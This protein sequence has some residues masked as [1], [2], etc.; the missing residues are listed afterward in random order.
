[1]AKK[2]VW[3]SF[4]CVACGGPSGG[5][6]AGG[7]ERDAGGRDAGVETAIASCDLRTVAMYC[8]EYDFRADSLAAYETAC[9]DNGGTWADAPCP[10]ASSLGGCRASQAGFGEL[11]NFFYE[12]GPYADA[13]QVM[14]LCEGGDPPSTYVAP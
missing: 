7:D 10:R 12:G 4:M 5:V 9:T 8:Q 1:M 6:D 14:Q 13:T 2:M 3:I 11:T